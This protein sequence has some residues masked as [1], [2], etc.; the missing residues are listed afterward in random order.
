MVFP[1]AQTWT[2]HRKKLFFVKIWSLIQVQEGFDCTH[3]IIKYTALDMN[4][5][6]NS[7]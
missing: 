7:G 4:L 2:I 1:R 5:L 6:G 3:L